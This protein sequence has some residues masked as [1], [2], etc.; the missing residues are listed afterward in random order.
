MVSTFCGSCL[1]D[2]SACQISFTGRQMADNASAAWAAFCQEHQ[3]N[4]T[5]TEKFVMA[6]GTPQES[7]HL[8]FDFIE[9]NLSFDMTSDGF[10]ETAEEIYAV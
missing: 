4:T 7:E 6:F 3:I 1:L 8:G 9:G 10:S 5:V 2:R